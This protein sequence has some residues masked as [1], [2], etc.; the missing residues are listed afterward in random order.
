MTRILAVLLSACL[1]A[2][3]AWAQ[4]SAITVQQPWARATP[5]G[6]QTGAVYM[7]IVNSGASGDQLV[8]AS[9]PVAGTAQVHEMSMNNGVMQMRPVAALDVK[10][11]ATVA[12]APGGYHIM[13]L[14][15]NRPLKDGDSFPMTLTFAK[16]GKQDVVVSVA[17]V[18]AMQP[19]AMGV[20]PGMNVK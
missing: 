9:T 8:A 17:K 19:D 2:S 7:T 18:G 3:L 4:S 20:M 1:G 12:L 10:P 14:G 6:A 16:S 15:L 11:G 13:L 5:G